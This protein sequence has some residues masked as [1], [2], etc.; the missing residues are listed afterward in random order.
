M[1]GIESNYYFVVAQR[2]SSPAP[3]V[4]RCMLR[5][6]N[7]HL[8]HWLINLRVMEHTFKVLTL[9]TLIIVALVGAMSG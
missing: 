3:Q 2:I 9:S 7:A 5:Q 6:H 8:S 4:T 1:F